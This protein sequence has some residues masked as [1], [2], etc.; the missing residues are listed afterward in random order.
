M[1]T[2]LEITSTISGKEK[3]MVSHFQWIGWPDNDSPADADAPF[4]LWKELEKYKNVVV[5]C[6]VG[7][8]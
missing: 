1:H 7:K 4:L 5:H 8:I 6:S 3:R 2:E